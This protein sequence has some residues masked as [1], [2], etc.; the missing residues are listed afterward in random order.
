M[1]GLASGKLLVS[2]KCILK[3]FE[4]KQWLDPEEDQKFIVLPE[5]C[6][7]SR[8]ETKYIAC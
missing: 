4:A 7:N 8:Y 6:L 1:C 3:S 2:R 5:L